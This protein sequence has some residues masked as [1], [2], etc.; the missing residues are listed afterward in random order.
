MVRACS[1][2]QEYSYILISD[3]IFLLISD[4][5]FIYVSVRVLTDTLDL[6]YVK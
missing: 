4:I 2:T 3:I 6:F 5:I 1:I